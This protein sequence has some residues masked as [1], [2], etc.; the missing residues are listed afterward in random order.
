[1]WSFKR[2]QI[3]CRVQPCS[4]LSHTGLIHVRNLTTRRVFI[5]NLLNA[6]CRFFF[7]FS[8]HGIFYRILLRNYSELQLHIPRL[9]QW[10]PEEEKKKRPRSAPCFRTT[11]DSYVFLFASCST[12]LPMCVKICGVVIHNEK[13]AQQSMMEHIL[14][15]INVVFMK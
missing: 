8:K 14:I 13:T 2:Q 12:L 11:P 1:M 7:C 6:G 5:Q 9:D 10:K 3:R 15:Y 4:L